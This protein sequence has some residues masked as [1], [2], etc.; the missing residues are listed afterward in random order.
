MQ[1]IQQRHSRHLN[2]DIDVLVRN[3]IDLP[4]DAN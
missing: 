2:L 3:R 4:V 1:P